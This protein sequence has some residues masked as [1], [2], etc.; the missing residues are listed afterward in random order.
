[1]SF[2]I[3]AVPAACAI[4]NVAQCNQS[5]NTVTSRCRFY[6]ILAD[7]PL[8]ETAF[9]DFMHYYFSL[10]ALQLTTKCHSGHL[11]PRQFVISRQQGHLAIPLKPMKRMLQNKD[12][13]PGLLYGNIWSDI[14]KRTTDVSQV[15][16]VRA[17]S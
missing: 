5:H 15:G 7:E 4:A 16:S 13:A 12:L 3:S 2:L 6:S 14:A 11:I 8:M 10:N 9:L 1:M 17:I